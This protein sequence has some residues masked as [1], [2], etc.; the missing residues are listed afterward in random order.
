MDHRG[1]LVNL[2]LSK[3]VLLNCLKGPTHTK[4]GFV[5]LPTP[6]H[7]IDILRLG[8]DE[9]VQI[10]LGDHG[11]VRATLTLRM[12]PGG[13][14]PIV[15]KRANEPDVAEFISALAAGNNA[16]LMVVASASTAASITLAL[17]A[18][19]HQTGGRVVCIKPGLEELQLSKQALGNSASNVEF[20][21]GEA[22]NV[23][24]NQYREADFV[25]IDC[26]LDSHEGISQQCKRAGDLTA[27][28]F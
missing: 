7:V 13:N 24:L 1:W 11:W 6:Q 19:A 22:Q 25:V 8:L 2:K 28:S 10:P 18:A 3:Y 27:L 26:N 12:H 23:L 20:V 21:M 5:F 4:L 14:L 9:T 17:V 15:G 16:Q